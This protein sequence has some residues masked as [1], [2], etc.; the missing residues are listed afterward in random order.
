MDCRKTQIHPA[1]RS[2]YILSYGPERFPLTCNGYVYGTEIAKG[3]KNWDS[4]QA[5]ELSS[6]ILL[7]IRFTAAPTSDIKE[8]KEGATAKKQSR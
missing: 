8:E 5:Y 4:L 1:R 3:I 6:A 7:V 2:F